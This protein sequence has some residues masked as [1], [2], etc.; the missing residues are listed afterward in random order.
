LWSY[1][2]SKNRLHWIA[3]TINCVRRVQPVEHIRASSLRSNLTP[4]FSHKKFC[5]KFDMIS[6]R[7]KRTRP[8]VW[9]DICSLPFSSLSLW[10]RPKRMRRSPSCLSSTESSS[11]SYSSPENI[12]PLYQ[13]LPVVSVSV[14]R[15][16]QTLSRII[17]RTS[18]KQVTIFTTRAK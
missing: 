18:I 6:I 14:Y 7:V 12:P 10:S 1:S 9:D 13:S 11:S 16:L 17:P 2:E 8:R 5:Q 15:T 4:L 3:P